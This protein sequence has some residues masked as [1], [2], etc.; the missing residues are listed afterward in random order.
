MGILYDGLCVPTSAWACRVGG[1]MRSVAENFFCSWIC[2]D[3]QE[4]GTSVQDEA[5]EQRQHS[6]I[7]LAKRRK[8]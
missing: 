1:V 3:V 8:L 7:F 5:I 2:T 4:S 6:M